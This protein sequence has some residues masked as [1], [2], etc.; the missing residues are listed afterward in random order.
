MAAGKQPNIVFILLDNVGW[1]NFGV[2]GGTIP[3]P[4]IDRMASEG[5][6][7][8]NY[9][10]EAQCTPS[11]SAILTGRHPVRSGTCEVPYP[12]QGQFGLAPWEYTTPNSFPTPAMRLRCTA[13]GT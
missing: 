12:G 7:Y 11:R 9:N 8:N 2:Y 4:R 6:R 10:V 5:I 13:S 1:G 3:T